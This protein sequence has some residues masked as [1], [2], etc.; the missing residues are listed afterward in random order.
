MRLLFRQLLFLGFAASFLHAGPISFNTAMPVHE[1]G[2]VVRQQAVWVQ[3]HQDPSSLDRE[4]DVFLFPFTLVYG[5]TSNL[6]VMGNFPYLDKELGMGSGGVVRENSGWGD[7]TTVAR[8]EIFERNR[9]GQTVRG[10]L[11]AGLEWPTGKD[12]EIDSLGLLPPD[13]Q[14]GS[15]SFD[16]IVGTVWT[17]QWLSFQIDADLLYTRNNEA[18]NFKFG[19]VVREDLSFQYRLWPRGLSPHGVPS[20]V[21]GV[22]E[23][24][25]LYQFQNEISDVG[26]EDSGGY[27]LFLTPGVQWVSRRTVLDLAVQLP[28][29]QNLHGDALKTDFQLVAGFQILF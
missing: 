3:M 6:A 22:L 12:D 14:V 7:L 4:M 23:A 13:L 26:D 28:T 1:G 8:Y 5:A 25:S 29:I 2:I 9:L 20:Y 18:N 15:G 24:N 16:L 10:A 17:A 21:Y 11:F 19:D 27:Q